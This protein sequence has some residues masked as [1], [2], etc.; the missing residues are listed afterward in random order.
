MNLQNHDSEQRAHPPARPAGDRCVA[1]KTPMRTLPPIRAAFTL[2]LPLLLAA[3]ATQE[4]APPAPPSPM[5]VP[6]AGASA[7]SPALAD[8]AKRIESTDPSAERFRVFKGSG[9][10]VK[11][12]AP[13]G[14]LPQVAPPPPAAGGGVVLNFEGADL[15]EVV[16][17]ILGDILNEP[18]LIDASVGGQ[19]TIRT[20]TGLPR[21]AL[22][23]TLETLL[24][25]NGATMIKEDGLWK[26]VPTAN[27]VR[28]NVTPQLGNSQRALPPGFS[29]QIVPLRYVGAREMIRL[30]EPFAKD[31]AAVRADENRNLLILSGTEREL[32]HLMQ[33]VE[34]FDIDWMA[35]M[36]AGV[37]TLQGSDVKTVMTELDK[38]FGAA[39]KSPLSGLLRIVPIE[40]MNALLVISPNPAYLEEAKKWIERL[41]RG[42]SSGGL[43]FF[44]YNLQNQRAEKLAPLL[45]QAITGRA[46]AAT[47]AAAPTLAPGTPAGT[48]VNPPTFQSQPTPPAPTIVVQPP[49]TT[50]TSAQQSRAGAAGEGVG[51]ARN[52]QI[53]ADRDNN[54]IIVV[55]TSAEYSVLEAALKRLDVP[56]RQVMI[57]VVIAE[58]FLR[59]QFEFGVEWYFTN[60][61]NQAGGLFR[62]GTNP[63]NIFAPSGTTTGS[64]GIGPAVP[65]FS[66]LLQNLGFPGGIQAAV[67]L[68][69]TAGNAKIVANPHVAA[70]DN[71]KATIKVGDRIPINQQTYVGSG[72]GAATN[73]VTTTS[74]YIDTGVLLS[75]TPR[76]N[77]GGLVTLD[78]QAEVSNPGDA[79]VGEAPPI[80]TR[81]VQSIL[82]VQSGQTMIMGGLIK[83][84]KADGSQ[85]IP[86][87]AKIP[88]IGAAFGQQV[89]RNDRT[90][91]VLFITPRVVE[92]DADLKSITDDLR[93]R[94]ERL[95]DYF[96]GA[97][98]PVGAEPRFTPPVEKTP[99]SFARPATGPAAA[100]PAPAPAVPPAVAPT[101]TPAPAPAAAPAAP[102]GS[103]Y[104]PSPQVP[105]V[106]PAGTPPP[107]TAQTPR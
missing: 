94:M 13:G 3:C 11:G 20:S 107:P 37:F 45:Q 27:A 56:M 106:P 88:I 43:R 60:G 63:G 41:D 74:Q 6:S 42:D 52:V 34:M 33:T 102:A 97:K 50:P 24:R 81:S 28:G 101:P 90:E 77:A 70:L 21:E 35:G 98:Y 91:L 47:A 17:N 87:L 46:P 23:S 15:R 67:T 86:L 12:Q 83:E 72:V 96:P 71:Q 8:A 1:E 69:G 53:V 82:M 19:V 5:A 61:K 2:A 25:M 22:P 73:A 31:A 59:D 54:T 16:R 9:V 65:G 66:Y 84:T 7:A 38:V 58:V 64:V 29:V 103:A 10:V 49:A 4:T 78:V 85:G 93:R 39:D 79:A 92:N 104:A 89:L 57:E 80:N 51:V 55:A 14:G 18:Y 30:L 62:T 68:L 75:V 44:V 100:A 99:G 36:S 32:R 95:E 48:I 26:I 76:I 105:L 40:R